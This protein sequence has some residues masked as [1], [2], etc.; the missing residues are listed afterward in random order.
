MYNRVYKYLDENSILFQKQFE[1]RKS[2]CTS[3]AFADLISS[4]YNPFT[5]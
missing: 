5:K 3:H 4:I 1:F 2:H